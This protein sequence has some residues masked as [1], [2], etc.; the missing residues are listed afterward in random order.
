MGPDRRCY[1]AFLTVFVRG[2]R[3]KDMGRKNTFI[4]NGLAMVNMLIFVII[5][6]VLS[7]VMM[8]VVSSSSRLLEQHVRRAK[9]YYAAEGA[10]VYAMDWARRNGG[11]GAYV[12]R[13]VVGP[14]TMPWSFDPSGN[15]LTLKAAAFSSSASAT[16]PSSTY[17]VN[18]SVNYAL[19]W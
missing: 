5:F 12:I 15:I 8:T 19:N 17:Q 9:A 18:G 6:T 7:G 3:E 2:G 13:P 16:G 1:L 14:G 10:A 4:P 11:A